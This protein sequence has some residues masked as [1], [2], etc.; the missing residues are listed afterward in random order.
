MSI[1]KFSPW[2][3]GLA[4]AMTL[5]LG[6]GIGALAQVDSF[7]APVVQL[8]RVEVVGSAPAGSAQTLLA[9]Q[10]SAQRGAL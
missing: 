1:S 6:A 2:A 4:L 5:A 8:E 3:A 9:D 10:H 7:G